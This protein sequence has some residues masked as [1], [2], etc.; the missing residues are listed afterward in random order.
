MMIRFQFLAVH[1]YTFSEIKIVCGSNGTTNKQRFFAEQELNKLHYRFSHSGFKRMPE[2]QKRA[3]SDKGNKEMKRILE[4]I[5][6]DARSANTWR[7]SCSS[8]KSLF[9]EQTSSIRAK[10]ELIWSGFWVNRLSMLMT[11]LRI[12]KPLDSCL[13][14]QWRQYG[15]RSSKRWLS[16]ISALLKNL[17][18][19]QTIQF[20]SP[21]EQAIAAET[22]ISVKPVGG[23]ESHAMKVGERY[24]A[25]LRKTFLK[26][27]E[28]YRIPSRDTDVP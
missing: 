8:S 21:K 1:L 22:V 4:K 12:F 6:H 18:Y 10:I 16:Y 15:E 24:H 9:P 17:R 19:D 14:T 27:Q 25:S 23:G 28:T 11:G 3:S 5:E 26:L 13:M 7:Q 2:F 20:I